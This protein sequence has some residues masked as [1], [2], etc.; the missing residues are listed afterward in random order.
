M[1]CFGAIARPTG[2]EA[3]TA[4]GVLWGVVSYSVVFMAVD[5]VA[6]VSC[7]CSKQETIQP[8]AAGLKGV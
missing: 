2:S 3:A 7:T 6:T 4:Q 1:V 8:T 5:R